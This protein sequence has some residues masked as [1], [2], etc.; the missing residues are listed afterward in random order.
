MAVVDVRELDVGE[1]VVDAVVLV[2]PGDVAELALQLPDGLRATVC[3]EVAHEDDR[4]ALVGLLGDDTQQVGS[5]G[6]AARRAARVQGQGAVVVHEKDD[7]L[8][9]DV[10]EP[11]PH[12]VARAVL[13]WPLVRSN[14]LDAATQLLPA[15]VPPSDAD[16]HGCTSIHVPGLV[17]MLQATH[18]KHMPRVVA[19]LESHEVVGHALGRPFDHLRRL[20]T[21]GGP[22]FEIVTHDLD[23]EICLAVV[24]P[25]FWQR[26]RR[27][28]APGAAVLKVSPH[29]VALF[30]R[31]RPFLAVSASMAAVHMVP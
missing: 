8:G 10:L 12:G 5:R 25:D 1:D 21:T 7:L 15:R 24:A 27:R 3:I 6:R 4:V 22:P 31:T 19:L 9:L 29:A 20:T 17:L 16:V 23:L 28:M 26:G 11:R 14:L 18:P 2:A 30:A 13:G